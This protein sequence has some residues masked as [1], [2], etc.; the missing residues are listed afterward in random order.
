M[1]KDTKKYLKTNLIGFI[2]GGLLISGVAVYAAITFPSNDVS[3][4]N[5]SS[6]LQ[7]TS[8]KDAIDELYKECTPTTASDLLD[9]VDV[10][11]SGDGLYKDE[12]ENRYFY[13]GKNVNNYITF[14]NETSGWRIISLEPDGTIKIMK[15]EF[16]GYRPF[17]TTGDSK[18]GSN[19]WGRPAD[20][21]TY[22]NETYY[23][24]LT[25]TARGQIVAHDFSVGGVT[26][27]NNDLGKNI[28]DEN[29]KKWNG[30]IALVTISEFLRTNSDQNQCKTVEMQYYNTNCNNTT[31]M[32]K[33][34]TGAYSWWSLTP[35][36]SGTTSVATI[37][38]YGGIYHIIGYSSSGNFADS[39][40]NY[41]R[42]VLYL[43]ADFKLSG[44]GTLSDPYTISWM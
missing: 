2:L 42:P 24:S 6:G 34:I 18:F 29:S 3:Y 40:H 26:F 11:T 14:N 39:T 5:S 36:S 30:K 25:T 22:L 16:I 10:V 35:E 15:N 7:A 19:N 13:K 31:W 21:N 32:A 1:K 37:N 41:I 44:S 20:L 9:K 17:D 43:S 28:T 23:N 12:Y 38:N 8:V 33:A 4:D 27:L